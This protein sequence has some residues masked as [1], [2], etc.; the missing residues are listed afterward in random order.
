M[1]NELFVESLKNAS[2]ETE[3]RVKKMLDEIDRAYK[4]IKIK[5]YGK[6][7]II[8]DIRKNKEDSF[9]AIYSGYEIFIDRD[10][11]GELGQDLY[12]RVHDKKGNLVIDNW[13]PN[14]FN[15]CLC[16]ILESILWK[17]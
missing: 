9:W 4:P 15:D 1:T 5:V 7:R 6:N 8:K 11:D 10:L 13:M 14:N 3:E 12:Y 2:S 16:K 17:D